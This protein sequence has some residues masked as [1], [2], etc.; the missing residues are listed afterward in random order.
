MGLLLPIH[1]RWCCLPLAFRFYLQRKT[2][3]APT[4]RP[5]RKP[6]VFQDKFS[7]VVAMLTRLRGCFPTVPI[8]VVT[9]SW[10]GN[11]GLFRPM[12]AQCGSNIDLLARMRVNAVL[13]GFS[14]PTPGRTG[15]PRKYGQR[16]GKVADLAASQRA[17]AQ[18]YQV[19][20]YGAQ[21][22]V[23]A[24]D[25]CLMLK[26][27]RCPV[28]VVWVYRQTQW[29]ALMT[30]DLSLTVEQIIEYYSARWKIDAA[31]NLAY[32]KL[33]WMARRVFAA[34]R[35]HPDRRC[36]DRDQREKPPGFPRGKSRY[37]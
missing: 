3:Q 2:I 37:A 13:F 20:V 22:D 5:R 30:T 32:L 10:F 17:K 29:V 23:L 8:L 34:F 26:T 28:R 36:S 12:R 19:H 24:S 15:R 35:C 25:Q 6:L 14:D 7:Q 1:G 33:H 4:W 21:R 18:T 27:L 9:D 16:L 31:Y 11:N